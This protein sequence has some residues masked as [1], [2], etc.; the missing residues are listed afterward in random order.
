M[1]CFLLSRLLNA[2]LEAKTADLVRQAEQLMVSLVKNNVF[3]FCELFLCVC[4][5]SN[6]KKSHW[7]SQEGKKVESQRVDLIYN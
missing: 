7:G 4:Q 6:T 5:N 2:E 1:T 3:V